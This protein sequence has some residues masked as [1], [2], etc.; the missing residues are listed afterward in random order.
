MPVQ[1]SPGEPITAVE[2]DRLGY[3]LTRG[4]CR[5][6]LRMRHDAIGEL[7]ASG[8][9]PSVRVRE[10][11]GIAYRVKPADLERLEIGRRSHEV[12]AEK[13][14]QLVSAELGFEVAATAVIRAAREQKISVRV[15][16]RGQWFYSPGAVLDEI[17]AGAWR[18]HRMPTAPPRPPRERVCVNVRCTNGDDGGRAR[19]M[20]YE[21]RFDMSRSGWACCLDCRTAVGKA[22]PQVRTVKRMCKV[23]GC[24]G[25][26]WVTKRQAEKGTGRQRCD[27]C[28][29]AKR[30]TLAQ[31]KARSRSLSELLKDP[32]FA[33]ASAE[34]RTASGRRNS[35]SPKHMDALIKARTERHAAVRAEREATVTAA[36]LADPTESNSS[37]I[38]RLGL[39]WATVASV[40]ADLEDAKRIPMRGGVPQKRPATRAPSVYT[41]DMKSRIEGSALSRAQRS[42]ARSLAA[43]SQEDALRELWATDRTVPQIAEEIGIS[44]DSVKKMRQRLGLPPRPRG[45]RRSAE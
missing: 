21:S 7:L 39:A 42:S 34:R 29:A 15:A 44:I 1:D 27:A 37:L 3:T 28:V 16:R 35:H 17:R 40:R 18:P 24:T 33:Q 5:E 9:L 45:R 26:V 38:R 14:A 23:D 41:P 30:A 43:R 8:E 12:D 32:A 2:A 13:M 19:S 11:G 36:L 25:F 31:R 6:L 22:R 4:D 10:S 20:V